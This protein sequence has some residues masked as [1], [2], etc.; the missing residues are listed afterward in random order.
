L[1]I[2]IIHNGDAI[3]MHNYMNKLNIYIDL[4]YIAS[5]SLTIYLYPCIYVYRSILTK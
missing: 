1:D 2:Y 3:Y 5:N 4:E